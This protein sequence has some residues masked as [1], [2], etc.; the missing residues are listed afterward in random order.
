MSDSNPTEPD[1]VPARGRRERSARYPGAPLPEAIELARF[2]D[3]HGLDGTSAEAIA[4][5]MGF[6]SIKTRTFS[7]RLS[8][9]RQFGL[10]ALEGSSYRITPL[11]R[12]ILHPVDPADL[13]RL[14]REAM[15]A[16]PLYADLLVRLADRR[17]PDPERL[18]NLL[19][20]SYQITASAK[21]I[22]AESFVETSRFAGV[23]ADDGFLRP[24]GAPGPLTAPPPPTPT[25][26]PEPPTAPAARRSPPDPPDGVRFDLRLWGVD[27][28]KV[29]RVRAPESLSAESFSR[30]IEALRLH[31]RIVDDPPEEGE[32]AGS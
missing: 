13:P 3:D 19:Y 17:V 20:H 4:A 7:S 26:A 12:S 31:V 22:A 9:A 10:V 24:G 30:L 27:S 18:A 1:D 5:S 11:A 2:I 8:A 29:V 14:H 15:K 23:L 16:S 21:L 25:P 6:E 28:G 32:A